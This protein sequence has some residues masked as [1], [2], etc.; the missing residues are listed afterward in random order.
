MNRR[1]KAVL[2]SSAGL[3]GIAAIWLLLTSGSAYPEGPVPIVWD[4]EA[5]AECRMHVGEPRFAAQLHTDD[6]HILNFDDPGCALR[7][8][9]REG[10]RVR[11]LYFHH[12]KEE[13]WLKHSQTAFARSSPSPM[14]Y[15]LA[16]VPMGS[17]GSLSLREATAE[18][19]QAKATAAH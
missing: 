18:V 2:W 14:G 17:P 6:G 15:N 9:A 13:T 11:A 3:M 5:C 4:Q 12:E 8:V 19:T 16:A 10:P 7:F 1:E